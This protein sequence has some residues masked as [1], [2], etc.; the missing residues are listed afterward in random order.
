ML[1]KILNIM[2]RIRLGISVGISVGPSI[3]LE[4]TPFFWRLN[5]EHD[6]QLAFSHLHIGFIQLWIFTFFEKDIRTLGDSV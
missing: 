3:N 6:S 4:I 2:K 1:K 5:F